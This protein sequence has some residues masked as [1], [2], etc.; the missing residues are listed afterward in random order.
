[1][2]VPRKH[3]RFAAAAA[4]VEEMNLLPGGN[5]LPAGGPAGL[6]RRV[7]VPGE[8]ERLI[9]QLASPTSISRLIPFTEQDSSVEENLLNYDIAL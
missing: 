6:A 3:N 8:G 7:S 9:F 4:P 1:M 5:A 2:K